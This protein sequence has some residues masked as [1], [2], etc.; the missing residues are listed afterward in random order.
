[1]FGASRSA[2]SRYLVSLRRQSR[3]SAS[4]STNASSN[5]A[6]AA[7]AAGPVSPST[8]SDES[9]LKGRLIRERVS[10]QSNAKG[11][12]MKNMMKCCAFFPRPAPKTTQICL[13][14]SKERKIEPISL[15]THIERFFFAI[16]QKKSWQEQK[17]TS[18]KAIWK[19]GAS[20]FFAWIS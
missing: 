13:H 9:S 16:W 6:N 10:G 5:A 20:H 17:Q 7:A 12:L 19:Q 14:N 4:R 11:W 1:M 18:L 15:D 3:R 8:S 2:G